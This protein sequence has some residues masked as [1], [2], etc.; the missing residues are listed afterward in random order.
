MVSYGNLLKCT[1]KQY[2]GW[3]CQKDL[4]KEPITLWIWDLY[5][6]CG[7]KNFFSLTNSYLELLLTLLDRQ[8]WKQR[9]ENQYILV[10][11]QGLLFILAICY[12]YSSIIYLHRISR[13]LYGQG[14]LTYPHMYACSIHKAHIVSKHSHLE[15]LC[16]GACS[17]LLNFKN[18]GHMCKNMLVVI[19]RGNF[20]FVVME[21]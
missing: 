14:V 11:F 16:P 17:T 9:H 3:D 20:V 18:F 7:N 8:L 12:S 6:Q 15:N 5:L 4:L 1:N 19:L 2:G 10:K 13:L 21:K